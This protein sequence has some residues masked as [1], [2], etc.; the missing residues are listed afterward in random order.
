M[1]NTATGSD[2]RNLI[3]IPTGQVWVYL[4]DGV[5]VLL[6]SSDAAFE[7]IQRAQGQSVAHALKHGGWKVEA[8]QEIA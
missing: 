2:Y 3:D 7:Y 1:S 4:P 8:Y 5:R 6:K